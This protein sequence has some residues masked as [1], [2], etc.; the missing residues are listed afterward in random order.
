MISPP[1][2]I[3]DC[4][5][6]EAARDRRRAR[7]GRRGGGERAGRDDRSVSRIGEAGA[8]AMWSG[9]AETVP[10]EAPAWP[11]TTTRIAY[12]PGRGSGRVARQLHP[13]RRTQAARAA[14]PRGRSSTQPLPHRPALSAKNRAG[15]WRKSSARNRRRGGAS[16]TREALPLPRRSARAR[17]VR[18]RR[19]GGDLL[20]DRPHLPRHL[21]A[22]HA[23]LAT[24][25]RPRWSTLSSGLTSCSTS[26]RPS[27]IPTRM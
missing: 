23:G 1:K 26:R 11:G 15:A 4:T 5:S 8:E 12:A 17:I 20:R 25:A 19:V 9:G 16:R 7:V 27:R 10:S 18:V 13:P 24:A 22:V 21:L 3:S 14:S 2:R 6:L